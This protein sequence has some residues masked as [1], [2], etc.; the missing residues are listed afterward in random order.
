MAKSKKRIVKNPETFREKV[1][2]AN[3]PEVKKSRLITKVLGAP[4]RAI[5]SAYLR[6]AKVKGLK[7]IFKILS[8]L[9][10]IVWPPYFRNSFNELKGVT[11]PTPKM[12]VRLTYAV[13]AFAVVFGVSVAVVDYGLGKVFKVLLLK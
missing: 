5:R 9:G 3:Q 2:K 12:S 1:L 11:W 10:K 6:F 8:F 4:F 13:I 7:P